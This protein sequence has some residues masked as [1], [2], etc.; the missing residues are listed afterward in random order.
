[1][2]L[3]QSIFDCVKN[4]AAIKGM[5]QPIKTIARMMFLRIFMWLLWGV[6]SYGCHLLMR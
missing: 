2:V 5:P 4:I 3:R 6:Y 1:M